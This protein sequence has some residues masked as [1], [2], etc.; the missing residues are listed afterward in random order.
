MDF[1]GARLRP[2]LACSTALLALAAVS[3]CSQ[4][5]EPKSGSRPVDATS[6]APSARSDD[7]PSASPVGG[8]AVVTVVDA[9]AAPRRV[10]TLA[11]DEG[12]T[13]RTVLAMDT[14]MSVDIMSSPAIEL[15]VSLPWTSSVTSVDDAGIS[16]SIDFGVPTVDAKD[17]LV[18]SMLGQVEDAFALI[19]AATT[20]IVYAPSGQVVSLE[21]DLGDDAP[22][23]VDRILDDVSASGLALALPFPDEAVGIGARWT[24]DS[25]VT[26]GEVTSTVTTRFD[27]V[28]LTD[29]GYVVEVTT[30]Q[31]ALPGEIPGGLGKV[32]G[33]STSGKGRFEGRSGLLGPAA[34]SASSQGAATIELGGQRVTTTYDVATDVRTR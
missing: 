2:V 29:D 16:V 6:D 22:E 15:P 34:A 31:Q 27:L 33:G 8:P 17:A 32:V 19:D 12:H 9:G 26:V 13:E 18:K 3:G 7:S 5:P 1:L 10:V 4:D 14:S 11:V 25:E 23:I 28:D 24:L 20:E 21:T 30:T